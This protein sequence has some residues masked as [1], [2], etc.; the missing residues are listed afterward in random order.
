VGSAYLLIRILFVVFTAYSV[1]AW[2]R[3]RDKPAGWV[4]PKWETFG[5]WGPVDRDRYRFNA[6]LGIIGG[7]A[8]IAFTFLTESLMGSK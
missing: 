6:V 7:P 5:L 4:P 3:V 1:L 2:I 8:L